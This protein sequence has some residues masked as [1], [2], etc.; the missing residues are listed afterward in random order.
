V[1]RRGSTRR[2]KAFPPV[3]EGEELANHTLVFYVDEEPGNI[4]GARSSTSKVGTILRH[5]R[6]CC[7]SS[8]AQ[9]GQCAFFYMT[10]CKP[11]RRLKRICLMQAKTDFTDDRKKPIAGQIADIHPVRCKT[12]PP[13]ADRP[14]LSATIVHFPA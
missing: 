9:L 1:H 5:A 8:Y 7:A 4:G 12:S 13:A 3:V 11:P 10:C 2:S 6:S 14:S